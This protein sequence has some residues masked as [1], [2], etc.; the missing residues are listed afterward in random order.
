MITKQLEIKA[1]DEMHSLRD[2]KLR[3]KF[4]FYNAFKENELRQ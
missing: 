2:K 1:E 3:H 4:N